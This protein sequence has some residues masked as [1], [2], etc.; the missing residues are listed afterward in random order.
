LGRLILWYWNKKRWCR[1]G[2]GDPEREEIAEWEVTDPGKISEEAS[3]LSTSIYSH[4]D[5]SGV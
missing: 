3:H 2:K 5:L 1:T 4:M